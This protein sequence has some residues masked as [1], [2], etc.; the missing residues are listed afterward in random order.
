M[1]SASR[2]QHNRLI[3]GMCIDGLCHICRG[4]EYSAADDGVKRRD[5]ERSHL[6]GCHGSR[7]CCCR[8]TGKSMSYSGKH[9]WL[10][11]HA[12]VR[13]VAEVAGVWGEGCLRQPANGGEHGGR[14]YRWPGDGGGGRARTG[15]PDSPHSGRQHPSLHRL[16][17][18]AYC[19]NQLGN[20]RTSHEI[21]TSFLIYLRTHVLII[22]T[23]SVTL[24]Y[25][26][27]FYT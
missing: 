16:R 17:P 8:R 9:G 6:H 15:G 18:G 26:T 3:G 23:I 20:I 2:A 24:V 21:I 10:E 5:P 13:V 14:P 4:S 12:D 19:R 22:K 7:H 1:D 27:Y 11:Q 25:H